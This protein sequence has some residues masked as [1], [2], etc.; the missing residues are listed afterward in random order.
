LTFVPISFT[1]QFWLGESAMAAAGP[2]LLLLGIGAGGA[3][4]AGVFTILAF[5]RAKPPANAFKPCFSGP[6]P[7]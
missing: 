5:L 3:C 2:E 6:K 7:R 4:V 1:L